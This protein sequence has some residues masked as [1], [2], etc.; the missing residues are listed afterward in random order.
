MTALLISFLLFHLLLDL[1][2]ISHL[3]S[4]C[5]HLSI[6]SFTLFHTYQVSTISYLRE[7][8]KSY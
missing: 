3:H 7:G 6:S 2:S 1:P 8:M 4:V 5:I